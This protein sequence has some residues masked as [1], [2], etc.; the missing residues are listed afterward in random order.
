MGSNTGTSI[1]EDGRETNW[2][3]DRNLVCSATYSESKGDYFYVVVTGPAGAW[4]Y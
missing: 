4:S 1:G 2:P 3:T